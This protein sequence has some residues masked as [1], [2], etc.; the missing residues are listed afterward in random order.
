MAPSMSVESRPLE[1]GAWRKL[2]KEE[3]DLIAAMVRNS[4]EA[5]KIL[6]SLPKSLVKE[7]KDG[8]MGSLRFKD[9]DNG[10]RSF[11]K[12]IAEA[13]FADED[14]IPV[15]VVVNIDN[16]GDLLELDLWKVDFSPLKRYPRPEE[17][18]IRAPDS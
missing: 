18:R 15:S 8:G 11:G 3:V 6:R 17:L 16:N 7:M 5:N 12:K 9:V 4:P 13:E 10:E 1:T 2:R 14:G